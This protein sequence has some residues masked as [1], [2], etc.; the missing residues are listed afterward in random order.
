MSGDVIDISAGS[1]PPYVA[2]C[3]E[4]HAPGVG[5]FWVHAWTLADA[6]RW[7][8]VA[9]RVAGGEPDATTLALVQMVYVCRTGPGSQESTFR[10]NGFNPAPDIHRL[11]E[12]MPGPVVEAICRESDALG[13]AGYVPP[14]DSPRRQMVRERIGLQ[15]VRDEAWQ[16]LVGLVC[17]VFGAPPEELRITPAELWAVH[18]RD[19]NLREQ[20]GGVLSA[21]GALGGLG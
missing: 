8:D 18:D 13:M 1:L 17:A 10:I 7:R 21:V 14:A 3:V 2:P 9:H 5:A 11:R 6:A 19:I 20:L 12:A 15:M 16:H 4:R